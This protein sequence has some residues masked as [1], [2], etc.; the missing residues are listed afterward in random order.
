MG[1]STSRASFCAAVN[2]VRTNLGTMP[3]SRFPT[4]RLEVCSGGLKMTR[5]DQWT[6]EDLKTR[7][8]SQPSSSPYDLALKI[9][10]AVLLAVGLVAL[11][12]PAIAHR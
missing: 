9:G 3:D 8:Q 12:W 5:F 6:Q 1:R 4:L 11:L 2:S 10:V 7:Q